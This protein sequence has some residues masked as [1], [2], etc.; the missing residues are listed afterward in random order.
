AGDDG[1]GPLAVPTKEY[2]ARHPHPPEGLASIRARLP[3]S[4][5]PVVDGAYLPRDPFDPDAPAISAAVPLLIGNTHDEAVFFE[6]GNPAFFHNDKASVA[7]RARHVFG[8]D[9][10]DRVLTVYR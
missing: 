3:G 4:W 1:K 9:I 8:P 2:L 6:R 7:A 10:A 5:N